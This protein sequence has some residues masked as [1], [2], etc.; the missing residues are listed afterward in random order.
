MSDPIS[1][2]GSVLAV[3]GCAAETSKFLFK[4]LQRIP[5]LPRDIHQS[6]EALNSLQVTLL[7]LQQ[8]GAQ[9]DPRYRFSTQ[10]TRRIHECLHQLTDWRI[11][12]AKLDAKVAKTG[13]TARAWDSR[14]TRSWE[15][16]KWLLNGEQEMQKFLEHM[17][18]H[19]SGFSLELLALLI[20][21]HGC[22]SSASILADTGPV[23]AITS[24]PNDRL[25]TRQNITPNIRPLTSQVVN[26]LQDASDDALL[27]HSTERQDGHAKTS[28]AQTNLSTWPC[29]EQSVRAAFSMRSTLISCNYILRMG[30]VTELP[31]IN[32]HKAAGVAPCRKVGYGFGFVFSLPKR[33][34]RTYHFSL[35]YILRAPTVGSAKIAIHL[36]LDYPRIVSRDSNVFRLA[37]A[38]DIVGIKALFSAGLATPRDT[39]VYGVTLLH[40]ASRLRNTTLIRLLIQEGAD[41]NVPDE[42]GE[43]P[44]HGA[45]AFEDNY[46][47]ARLLI[48]NGADLA[49]QA[50]DRKTPL[51]TLFTST[52]AQV[53]LTTDAIEETVSDHTGMSITHFIAW[54][55]KSTAIDFQR[56]RMHDLTDLW[57][58]DN[59]GRTCL[60]FAASRGNLSILEYLLEQATPH[61]VRITDSQGYSPLHYAVRSTRVATAVDLMLAKGGNILA[62]DHLGCNILHHA[63]QWNNLEAIKKVLKLGAS[64]ALLAQDKHGR[65]PSQYATGGPLSAMYEYLSRVESAMSPESMQ[66]RDVSF[67]SIDKDISIRVQQ[68][69]PSKRMWLTFRSRWHIRQP[70]LRMETAVM[71]VYLNFPLTS[72]LN[73]KSGGYSDRIEN[74]RNVRLRYGEW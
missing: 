37:K 61:Q 60:H 2:V 18:L 23:P 4:F 1:A 30:P 35:Y 39:T 38:G 44:L 56:G 40:T 32:N 5:S 17:R 22:S 53:L 65:M 3:V 69:R 54:S 31:S 68:D 25:L 29:V 28:S 19:Q 36:S 62:K 50:T 21:I 16:I 33:Y 57:A 34:A 13:S 73:E 67:R 11:K 52:V 66:S 55:S 47:A 45:L 74:E 46:D 26:A 48:A 27:F 42:D 63:A 6:S 51:H 49:N 7:Q 24:I 64:K 58:P 14:V 15:K 71:Q 8:C 70:I 41:V 10:F 12:I 9:L 59:C 43:V 20:T 72:H